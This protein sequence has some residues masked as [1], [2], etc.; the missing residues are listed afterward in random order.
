[1]KITF[2][3]LKG[4]IKILNGTG[5]DEICLDFSSFKNR[6]I[7]VQGENGCGKSTIISALSPTPDSSDSFRTDVFIDVSGNRQ[8]VEYPAEKEI[9]YVDT[10]EYGNQN[11]YKILIL[12]IVDESRTRRTTKAFI[13]KNGEELN[14]NGNVSSFKEIRDSLLGIDPVYLDLSSISA[15]NRGIVDMI[16]SERRKYMAAYIGSLETYNNIFKTISKKVS[17]VKSYMNTLSTKLYELGNENELRLKLSQ[18]TTTLKD[19]NSQRD[20]LLKELASAEA[21]VL[22]IDPDNKMQDLY[23]SISERLR[24]IK[25]EMSKKE[26][27]RVKVST[28]LQ[29]TPQNADI[30]KFLKD[31]R[32]TLESYKNSLVEKK[33]KLST[34]ITLNEATIQNIESDRS[35]LD[36]LN[37]NQVHGNIVAAVDKIKSEISTYEQYL[38]DDT[39][40]ILKS[41]TIDDLLD[42]RE[43]LNDFMKEISSAEELYSEEEFI[44]AVQVA[45]SDNDKKSIKDSINDLQTQIIDEKI[46]LSQLSK[47][48]ESFDEDQKAISDFNNMRPND[49]SNDQCPFIAKYIDIR[50]RLVEVTSQKSITDKMESISNDIRSKSD[51]V[52][53]FNHVLEIS[54]RVEFAIS[55][56]LGKKSIISKFESL[57]SILDIQSLKTMISSHYRFPIFS[58]V[59]TVIE[60]ATIYNDLQN[61]KDQLKGLESDLSVYNK[62]KDLIDTLTTKISEN[63]KLKES[64]EEEIKSINRECG[65]ISGMI[66]EF[67]NRVENA[68]KLSQI[69]SDIKSLE[70]ELD[71]LRQEFESVKDKIKLVK[72][73]IDSVNSIKNDINRIEESISPQQSLIS[74]LNYDI[75]SI[76]EYQKEYNENSDIYEKIVFIRNACS[77]GNGMGIQSEYIKRYMNDIIIDCNR[78]LSYMFGGTVQLHVPVI[79]EKQFSI[80]FVGPNGI[81]VPDISDGSTA[82]KCMIGLVFSCVA[83]MK[84]SLKY[85]IPRFDEIDGGLDQQ[86]RTMFINVLNYILDFMHC[87]QCVICSHNMEFDTQSTTRLICSR[88]GI[89]IEQ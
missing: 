46:T 14:P 33:S 67:S 36:G 74:K 22:L 38:S 71:D 79:N 48:L 5:L 43:S 75:T 87:D 47:D 27:E 66:V 49:C 40:K 7:L 64:R 15:E 8:I 54:S 31:T 9:H 62:N 25:H 6:I 4:Y 21:T 89:T 58:V 35:M 57:K 11:Y 39:I 86:N 72:D 30:S 34:L 2:F 85:N 12:S 45:R 61:A 29:L 69:S 56:I 78:M 81:P 26:E 19:L 80:P 60:N 28:P 17:S 20:R 68:E 37:S 23:A 77:P 42:L 76:L 82:Q 1:M 88:N 16:P 73:K 50:N 83:M 53:F 70:S 84:S 52:D 44:N 32:D 10:D 41:I 51:K 3:R 18:A 63:E 65:F 24:T 55:I 59:T 13:S